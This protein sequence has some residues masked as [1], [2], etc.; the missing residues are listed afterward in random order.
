MQQHGHCKHHEIRIHPHAPLVEVQA[1]FNGLAL[2]TAGA[3]RSNGGRCRYKN[4]SLDPDTRKPH[5]V[6]EH[7]PYQTCL[8]QRGGVRIA[9]D[10]T[11]HVH[12]G[13]WF[14]GSWFHGANVQAN[15]T[16]NKFLARHG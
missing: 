15:G 16:V 10:P 9:I 11:L 13:V 14:A 6:C 4:E 2:Y 5:I 3:L 8:V 1:A 7:V 12:C